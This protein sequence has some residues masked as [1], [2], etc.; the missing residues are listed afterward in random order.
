MS[1]TS[2]LKVAIE[3]LTD[4]GCH[5]QQNE[6]GIRCVIPP[7]GAGG[8]QEG[9]I[10]VIADGMGGAL[11]GEVASAIAIRD[12]VDGYYSDGRPLNEIVQ[13]AGD[14]IYEC[15]KSREDLAGMGTT[16]VAL[17]IENDGAFAAYVGDSRLYLLRGGQIYQMTE[18]HSMVAEMV[19][20][21]Q[22]TREEARNHQDRNVIIRAL[23]TRPNVV[24]AAWDRP[25]PLRAGD[26]LVLSTDG[27]HDLVED[28]EILAVAGSRPAASACREL[29]E[30]AKARGGYD[31]ITI[32]IVTLGENGDQS[33]ENGSFATTREF[34]VPV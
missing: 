22:L 5:R 3:T 29:V 20:H 15:S 13:R 14:A 21:G 7:K 27:L 4:P 33:R 10:I 1:S 34:G 32:G 26:R 30:L 16:C 6:D 18:D 23:G 28:E 8:R 9:A 24:V 2:S 19:R 11:A 25:F 17:T 12:I 31:N